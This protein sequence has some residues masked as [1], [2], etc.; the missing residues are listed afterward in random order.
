MA[1]KIKIVILCV[2]AVAALFLSLFLFKYGHANPYHQTDAA[3]VLTMQE[4]LQCHDK[5]S[6]KPIY[7]CSGDMCLYSKNHS[8]MRPYP[9][10]RHPN[11]YAPL[12]EIQEAGCVLENGLTTC[13]SCHDLTKP[14][15]H[16]IRDG[17]QL[18]YICHKAL[19][20]TGSLKLPSQLKPLATEN[21]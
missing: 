6:K 20:P 2:A 8:L 5:S 17:D 14:P 9:P 13:L 18:C 15:P 11:E 19:R 7:I 21:F 16:L 1:G 10:M 12:P 3:G 4:C